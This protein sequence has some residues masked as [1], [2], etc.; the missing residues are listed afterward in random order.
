MT[1]T[2][3]W[4][5]WNLRSAH[6]LKYGSHF[7]QVSISFFWFINKDGNEIANGLPESG[8]VKMFLEP[9]T[10]HILLSQSIL[11]I[12]DCCHTISFFHMFAHSRACSSSCLMIMAKNCTILF[13]LLA[14]TTHSDRRRRHKMHSTVF[15]R[16]RWL[17]RRHGMLCSFLGHLRFFV[18]YIKFEILQ[19]LKV[20]KL[21]FFYIGTPSQSTIY[22]WKL[23][24]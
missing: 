14:W 8:K 24:N 22:I 13:Q 19:E 7:C 12:S 18:N 1:L 5:S 23:A 3:I 15:N 20:S 17:T 21:W 16:C 9:R 11:L 4:K 2:L 10:F 6:C